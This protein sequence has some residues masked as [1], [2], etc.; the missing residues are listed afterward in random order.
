VQHRRQV[1]VADEPVAKD[2]RDSLGPGGRREILPHEQLQ[3][4]L[5]IGLGFGVEG[6]EQ[7]LGSLYSDVLPLKVRRHGN[8]HDP[9]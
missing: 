5:D 9:Q 2:G 8:S 6:G 1:A 7:L 4:F 3:P